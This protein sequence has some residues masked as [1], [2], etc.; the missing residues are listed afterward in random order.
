MPSSTT[1]VTKPLWF[2]VFLASRLIC[3]FV[4]KLTHIYPSSSRNKSYF[5]INLNINRS[6]KNKRGRCS[7][8]KL[9]RIYHGS[10]SIL[11]NPRLVLFEIDFWI[12]NISSS[13]EVEDLF[14]CS[15]A[16]D[17]SNS[18]LLTFSSKDMFSILT[19][20]KSSLTSNNF[21]S[22]IFFSNS[23]VFIFSNLIPH[24]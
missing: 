24:S 18:K 11:N 19:K 23:R 7:W 22:K 8:H 15:L 12:C 10:R 9:R 5:L 17:M 13:L 3:L 21:S 6:L 14:I 2:V 20:F 16:I 4:L 1:K